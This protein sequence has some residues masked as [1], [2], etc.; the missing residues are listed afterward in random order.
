MPVARHATVVLIPGLWA[1][2]L[3]LTTLGRRLRHAG[4]DVRGFS[5]PSVH[6]G[7]EEN[8]ARLDRYLAGVGADTVHLVGHSLGGVLIRALFQYYPNQRPGRVV[9]LGAPHNG[10]RV[11]ERLARG[12]LGRK[13]L[14]R[15][16]AQMLAGAPRTWKLPGRELGVLS[17]CRAIGLGRVLA[18]LPR[19]NDG[20]LTLTETGLAGARDQLVLPVS[21]TG[22]LFSRRVA[23]QVCA[24]LETG[25]FARGV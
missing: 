20:V 10:S 21:H 2:R 7:F 3:C 18:R 9:T 25:R 23:R 1:P 22:M 12:A 13:L 6:S 19:P 14:G 8:A 4:Y 17:G 16:V 15:G 24:F 5:Y 11:A